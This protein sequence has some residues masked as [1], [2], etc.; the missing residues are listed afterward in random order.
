M[1]LNLQTQN[2]QM[3]DADTT[4]VITTEQTAATQQQAVLEMRAN[5][6]RGSLFDMLG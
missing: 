4:Q 5:L 6:P 1:M 3:T 2:S